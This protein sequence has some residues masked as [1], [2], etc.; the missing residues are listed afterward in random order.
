MVV[1]YF[2]KCNLFCCINCFVIF[3]NKELYV[4]NVCAEF[5]KLYSVFEI[6]YLYVS[7]NLLL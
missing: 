7:F 5:E 2:T 1:C 3:F 4:N 6:I